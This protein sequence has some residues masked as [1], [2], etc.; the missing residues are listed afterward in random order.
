[1]YPLLESFITQYLKVVETYTQ[2]H[3]NRQSK[4]FKY[5]KS[6]GNQRNSLYTGRPKIRVTS[7]VVAQEIILK[8]H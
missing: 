6:H 5:V 7:F 4:Y 3:F 8:I 2:S 1:M